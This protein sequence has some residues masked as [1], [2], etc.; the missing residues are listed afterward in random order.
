MLNSLFNLVNYNQG[1]FKSEKQA[2]YFMDLYDGLYSINKTHYN[3]SYSWDFSFNEEGI[4]LVTKTTVKGGTVIHWENT[5]E[6]LAMLDKKAK[7]Q[8][9]SN[10][11][12]AIRHFNNCYNHTN[13]VLDQLFKEYK[14]LNN[15]ELMAQNNISDDLFRSLKESNKE[16]INKEMTYYQEAIEWTLVYKPLN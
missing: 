16:K 4:Q 1:K 12:E 5:P 2:K 9:E 7:A 10:R 15:Q 6:H 13:E 11:E 3:S 8:E 14:I